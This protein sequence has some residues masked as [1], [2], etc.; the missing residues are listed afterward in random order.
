MSLAASKFGV[1][2]YIFCNSW[3]GQLEKREVGMSD[4]KLENMKLESSVQSWKVRAEVRKF[5]LTVE[6]INEVGK[7]AFKLERSMEVGKLN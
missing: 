4:I 1:R 5:E 2:N 6:R 7:P 3:K